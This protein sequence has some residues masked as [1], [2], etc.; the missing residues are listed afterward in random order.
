MSRNPSEEQLREMQERVA[1][2]A[3]PRPASPVIGTAPISDVDQRRFNAVLS[4]FMWTEARGLPPFFTIDM[5]P[6]GAP[7]QSRRDAWD[8]RPVVIRYRAWKDRLRAA[9]EANGWVLGGTLRAVFYIPMPPS[10]SKKKKAEMLYSPHKQKPDIDNLTKA[11]MDGF[12]KDDGHV[13]TLHVSKV[14]AEHGSIVLYF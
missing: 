10:W 1:G 2:S 13:H 6:M 12:N 11:T 5:D 3:S 14:W 4:D 9:C 8:P 7:R